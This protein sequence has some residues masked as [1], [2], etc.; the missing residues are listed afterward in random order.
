MKTALVILGMLGIINV[1]SIWCCMRVGA[2]TD[3]DM[4]KMSEL[5]TETK[6]NN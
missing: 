6:D 2:K 3:A 1:F 4:Y 5:Q